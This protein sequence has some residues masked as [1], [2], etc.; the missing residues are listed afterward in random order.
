MKVAMAGTGNVAQYLIEELPKYGHSVVVLTR[1]SKPTI[2]LEQ[3][4][5]DYTI[6]SLVSVLHDRDAIISAIADFSDPA[7]GAQVH[8][9][10]LEA[11]RQS[12]SCKTFIPSQWTANVED[13]P[14]EPV[15]LAPHNKVLFD[16]LKQETQIRWTIICNAWFAE[17]IVPASQRHLRDVG[18]IWAMDHPSKVFTIYGPGTQLNDLTSV[19]DIAK[20][21][22]VLLDS[23]EPWE[24][25][26]YL[27]GGQLSW[28]ELFAIIKKRDSE[29]TSVKKPL[30]DTVQQIVANESPESV[31]AAYFELHSY[32]GALTFP[33]E[34][35]RRHREK[36]FQGVHFRSVEEILD[37]AAA[38]PGKI[39]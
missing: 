25:Y 18:P 15:V 19:R 24:P 12:Q 39:L 37:D 21:V 2:T 7:A 9:T 3:R 17:Y 33:Q 29:W 23:K 8:L 1:S 13:H 11:C 27:S 28:N 10:M 30:A 22:A 6:S 16:R 20:A 4:E 38:K 35:V 26:T 36:Y 5:T 32:S 34:K 31:L 14:E